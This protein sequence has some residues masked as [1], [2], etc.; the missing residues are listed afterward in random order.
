M[1]QSGC[2]ILGKVKNRLDECTW[3]YW[4]AYGKPLATRIQSYIMCY[5][6]TSV[7]SACVIM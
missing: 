4:R 5:Y 6:V 2:W 7:K 3:P 1:D